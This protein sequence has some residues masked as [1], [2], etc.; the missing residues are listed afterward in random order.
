MH[1]IESLQK[2]IHRIAVEHG[3]WEIEK[4]PDSLGDEEYLEKEK[5]LTTEGDITKIAL[6]ITELSEAIEEVRKENWGESNEIPY[7]LGPDNKPEGVWV[8]LA[9]CIIRI[10]DFAEHYN[11]GMEALI[12]LKNK[13]NETRSYKHGGKKV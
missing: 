10:L 3:W 5:D 4:T 1:T 6:M 7:Y 2:K 9:D 8:E 12:E 11:I 13:Y